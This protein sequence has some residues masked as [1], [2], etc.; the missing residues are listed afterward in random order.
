MRTRLYL[1]FLV[2]SMLSK[3]N[4]HE[5]SLHVGDN[6]IQSATKVRNLGVIFDSNMSFNN[7]ISNISS[8]IRKCLTKD[9]T[10]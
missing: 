6:D 1:L 4:S 7:Q 5:L 3:F 10:D 8:F 2:L 9:A